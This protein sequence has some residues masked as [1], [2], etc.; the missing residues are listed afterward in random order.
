MKIAII[1]HRFSIRELLT[2]KL[3]PQRIYC[4]YL[5]KG[6]ENHYKII[7]KII[8]YL[9]ILLYFSLWIFKKLFFLR[10]N[11]KSQLAIYCYIEKNL[12]FF[13]QFLRFINKIF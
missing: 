6:I 1:A 7:T 11:T 10:V 9:L 3:S 12:D 13:I 2:T 4:F 8:L 5:Y